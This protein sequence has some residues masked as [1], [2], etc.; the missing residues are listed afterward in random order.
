MACE[1]ALALVVRL[2][3]QDVGV[4]LVYVV[5]NKRLEPSTVDVRYTIEAPPAPEES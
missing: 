4:T 5:G 2:R 1:R 3:P